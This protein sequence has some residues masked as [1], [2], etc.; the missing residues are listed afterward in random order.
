MKNL[1]PFVIPS[2]LILL[3]IGGCS[4][5]PDKVDTAA[6]RAKVEEVIKNSIRWVLTKDTTMLYNCFYHDSSLFWFSPDNAGTLSGFEAFRQLTEQLFMDPRFKGVKSDFK[7]LQVHFS[8]SGE[9]AWWSCYLDDFNEWDGKPSN[10]VNVRWTGVL[11]K[12]EG[13]WK[14]RQMH[15]SHAEEDFQK[16]APPDSTK[17]K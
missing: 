4:A 1:A 14:I 8:H 7:D 11:E 10:W 15:F 9:C 2:F 6:E 16:K 13:K 17:G 3:L 5:M 12:I